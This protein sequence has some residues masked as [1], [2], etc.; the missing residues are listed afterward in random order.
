M[1]THTHTQSHRPEIIGV[2]AHPSRRCDPRSPFR[3]SRRRSGSSPP[4]MPHYSCTGCCRTVCPTPCCTTTW[5]PSYSGT[6]RSVGCPCCV[7]QWTDPVRSPHSRSWAWR[8]I[9]QWG[10]PG[11]P[12]CQADRQGK[13]LPQ[14]PRSHSPHWLWTGSGGC[15][16]RLC[17]KD[18]G[19]KKKSIIKCMQDTKREKM[20][21]TRLGA[22]LQDN[23]ESGKETFSSLQM[24]RC[25]ELPE[26]QL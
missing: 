1:H 22:L 23:V 20:H 13:G 18:E 5:C 6:G 24:N 10:A 9:A 8:S 19:E 25:L 11:P 26:M 15:L 7:H 4:C 12:C 14:G 17:L 21:T 16:L 2:L 3:C